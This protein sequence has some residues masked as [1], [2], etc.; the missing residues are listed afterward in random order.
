MALYNRYM[1]DGPGVRKDA[2]KKKAFFAF[3]DIYI[4]RFWKLIELNLLYFICCIPIIT[5]GP[6]TAGFTYVLRNWARDDHAFL[7]S[8]FWDGA[9]KNWK[10]AFTVSLIQLFVIVCLIF[11]ILQFNPNDTLFVIYFVVAVC[12]NVLFS[13]MMLY[14][15]PMMVTFKFNLKQLF[16]NAFIF[17]NIGIK[18]NIITLLLIIILTVP[19]FILFWFFPF[20]IVLLPTIL[21]STIGLIINF[22]VYPYLEKYIIEPYYKDHPEERKESSNEESLFNDERIIKGGGEEENE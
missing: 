4:K 10:Q 20:I 14:V 5:I 19:F 17:A 3:F 8:D 22:N 1:K 2:P 18:T 6:A 9:R 7:L 11:G 16:K 15:Y 13:M 12:I 21:L